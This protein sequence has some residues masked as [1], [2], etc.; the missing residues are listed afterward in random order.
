MTNLSVLMV[1]DVLRGRPHLEDIYMNYVGL[2][3]L[4]SC[5]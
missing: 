1:Y 3:W 2:A 4:L 5:E